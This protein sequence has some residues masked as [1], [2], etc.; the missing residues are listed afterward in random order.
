MRIL[1]PFKLANESEINAAGRTRVE[2]EFSIGPRK[3]GLRL[4]SSKTAKK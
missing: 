1:H 3:I 2:I 4:N